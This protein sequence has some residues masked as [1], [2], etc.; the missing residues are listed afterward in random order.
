MEKCS[1]VLLNRHAVKKITV[2][3]GILKEN[4]RTSEQPV[5]RD[6]LGSRRNK[7]GSL[8]YHAFPAA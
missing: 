2:S 3:S 4:E 6:T 5:R 8:Q 7:E 1:V